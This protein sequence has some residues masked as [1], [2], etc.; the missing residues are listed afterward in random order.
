MPMKIRLLEKDNKKDIRAFKKLPF[1][2]YRGNP[3][4][5][6]PFPGLVEKAM[7]P[8]RHPF[9]AHSEADFFLVEEG[10][11]VLGR[12]AVLHNRN[13]SQ[14]HHKQIAFFYYF[15]CEND[16]Q[17]ANLLFS[18]IEDWCTQRKIEQ[19]SG[20][21]GFLRSDGI[22]MLI[23]GFDQLPAMGV[24][25]NLPYYQKLVEGAGY[26]KSHDH[27]SGYLD[28]HPEPFIHKIAE[29]VLQ[30]GQFQVVNF[31]SINQL[32]EWIPRVDEVEHRAFVNNPSFFPSTAA[33]FEA[34]SRNI[35]AIADPRFIKIIQHND[36]VAG[37]IVAYLN[38]NRAL[39]L[40]KGRL[41]PFGWLFYLI[42]KKTSRILDVNGVGLLPEYQG[43]GGNAL[44]YS[45]LDKVTRSTRI[46]KAEIVQVDERNLRSKADM[47]NL[48]VIF[49]KTHRT[50][51]KDLSS[52]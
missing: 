19:I 6:P 44:L 18:A 10:S 41:F 23:E 17:V 33:E 45:E 11:E 13:Y 42:E 7:S 47:G 51:I 46:K 32:L 40:S 4:W 25:Y 24:P 38:I 39:Q 43:L 20:P 29:K 37:F 9:Y 5:V 52:S 16:Q 26:T 3:Y 31:T 21:R 1:R 27:Y 48:G 8:S 50:Y 22:G 14:H 28:R 30:K 34:L 35:L 15:E 2:L 12:I 49:S 36:E